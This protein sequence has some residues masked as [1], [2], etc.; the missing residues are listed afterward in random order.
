VDYMRKR[1]RLKKEQLLLELLVFEQRVKIHAIELKNPELA[2]RKEKR[3][4]G[5]RISIKLPALGRLDM[6]MRAGGQMPVRGPQMG[7]R[8]MRMMFPP[9]LEP[10]P[11]IDWS[12]YNPPESIFRGMDLNYNL[13]NRLS[14]HPL[15]MSRSEDQFI[16]LT[17]TLQWSPRDRQP[18]AHKYGHVLIDSKKITSARLRMGRNGRVW[19]DQSSR[20]QSRLLSAAV[21]DKNTAMIEP[22][23]APKRF[24]NLSDDESGDD[25]KED[26]EVDVPGNF[27]SMPL[28][29]FS[30]QDLHQLNGGLETQRLRKLRESQRPGGGLI[31]AAPGPMKAEDPRMRS[32]S[33]PQRKVPRMGSSG[34]SSPLSGPPPSGLG[35]PSSAAVA[36]MEKS[37]GVRFGGGKP[38]TGHPMLRT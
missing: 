7:D 30:P 12:K 3:P 15:S 33:G 22:R 27:F 24:F 20:R 21:D 25:D 10:E 4:E 31:M 19:I 26:D 23:L 18:R 32:P 34:A 2:I 35:S 13:Y 8:N 5:Q 28:V 38:G 16:D 11:V 14:D 9:P 17:H 6:D 1:D 37:K 29:L 36:A